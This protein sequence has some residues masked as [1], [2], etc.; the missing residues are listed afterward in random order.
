M[1]MIQN[2]QRQPI[3]STKNPAQTGPTTGPIKGPSDQHAIARPLCSCGIR[4][5]MEPLPHVKTVTPAKPAKKRKATSMPMLSASAQ[6]TVKTMKS[7]LNTWYTTFR[8]Y[9]SLRGAM[10]SGPVA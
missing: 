5:T 8:P 1:A 2:T 6:A 4:S 3:S 9:S 10:S 7:T